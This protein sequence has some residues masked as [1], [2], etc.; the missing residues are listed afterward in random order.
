M[1][2]N[3]I[4]VRAKLTSKRFA[5]TRPDG[6]FRPYEEPQQQKRQAATIP[7]VPCREAG[8]YPDVASLEIS[9]HYR[10]FLRVKQNDTVAYKKEHH[11]CSP[12]QCLCL[13]S[14][15]YGAEGTATVHRG[16]WTSA[17]GVL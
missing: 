7:C 13:E 17:I 15:S 1:V 4:G 16:E 11:D 8:P 14:R 6:H 12:A 3:I 5:V 10:C 9:L 2:N